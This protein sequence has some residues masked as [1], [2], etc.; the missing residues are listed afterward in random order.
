MYDEEDNEIRRIL[1]LLRRELMVF[2]LGLGLGFGLGFSL[3]F[4][5]GFGHGLSLGLGLE[6]RKF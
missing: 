2:G 4:S 6:R 5:R 3:G 1:M